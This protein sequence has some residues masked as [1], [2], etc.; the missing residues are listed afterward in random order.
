MNRR[1]FLL[2]LP[3]LPLAVKGIVSNPP[4]QAGILFQPDAIYAWRGYGSIHELLEACGKCVE[5]PP[6]DM[7]EIF[8]RIYAVKR[9]REAEFQPTIWITAKTEEEADIWLERIKQSFKVERI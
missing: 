1:G 9:A 8:Q 4:V 6:F 3:F 2:S 5:P 7:D